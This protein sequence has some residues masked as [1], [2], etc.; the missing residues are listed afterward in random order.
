MAMKQKEKD[1]N[2]DQEILG[3]LDEFRGASVPP[4]LPSS[5][6]SILYHLS[7]LGC[8]FIVIPDQPPW[9]LEEEK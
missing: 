6:T 3:L 2:N 5:P 7:Q 8:R 9:L 1:L 4:F